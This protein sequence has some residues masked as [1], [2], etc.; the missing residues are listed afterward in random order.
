MIHWSTNML[1][2]LEF[3]VSN[4]GLFTQNSQA[5]LWCQSLL[6]ARLLKSNMSTYTWFKRCSRCS[7][8]RSY[9][10]DAVSLWCWLSRRDI[11]ASESFACTHFMVEMLVRISWICIAASLN[12]KQN[13]TEWIKKLCDWRGCF[14]FIVEST[15]TTSF[16]SHLSACYVSGPLLL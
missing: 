3:G 1:C 14:I 15:A 6:Y 2:W 12:V 4:W 11:S 8:H 13:Y 9:N 7:Y 10:M 5:A 16:G